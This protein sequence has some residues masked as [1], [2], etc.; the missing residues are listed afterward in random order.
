MTEPKTIDPG[1]DVSGQVLFTG[2]ADHPQRATCPSC[3]EDL[4]RV[5]IIELAY[6]FATC[7]ADHVPYAHLYEQLWHLECLRAAPAP[8]VAARRMVEVLTSPRLVE[9]LPR[10][11]TRYHATLPFGETT[12][13][14]RNAWALA[15][16]IAG[17]YQDGLD[18]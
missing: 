9:R 1:A 11:T 10:P 15:E 18:E 4:E 3:G 6:V 7:E 13:G 17:E 2:G 14:R 5:A 12:A 16:A 8:P